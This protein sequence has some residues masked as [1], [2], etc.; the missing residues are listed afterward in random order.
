MELSKILSISGLGGLFHL[1]SQRDNGLIVRPLEGGKTRFVSSRKHLFTPLE[2]ITIYTLDDSIAL[3]EVF[4][5][6]KKKSAELSLPEPKSDGAV[7]HEYMTAVIPDDDDERVYTS[8][9]RKIV[10][11]YIQLDEQGLVTVKE[12]K[13]GEE[14]K[15]DESAGAD[16]EIEG[17]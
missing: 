4:E 10:K 12:E 3:K 17:E 2:N 16:G 1:E 6:M 14:G 13:E 5:E 8:D 11:W 7:L 15:S 9:I